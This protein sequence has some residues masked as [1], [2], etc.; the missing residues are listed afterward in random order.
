MATLVA[1]GGLADGRRG[2]WPLDVMRQLALLV[3]TAW[4]VARHADWTTGLIASA[5]VATVC[6]VLLLRYRPWCHLTVAPSK[7]PTRAG[8]ASQDV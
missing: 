8:V 1:L 3:V 4:A 5:A 6:A 7:D 2:A